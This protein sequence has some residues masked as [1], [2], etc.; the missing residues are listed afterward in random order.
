MQS[1]PCLTG[2][3]HLILDEIHERDVLSDFILT[4]LKRVIAVRK[5]L[6]LILMS[7]TLNAESFSK[8]YN[9]CPHINIPGF[10]YP[11]EEYY[12]EDVIEM[13]QFT[14]NDE[15]R[16]GAERKWRNKKT[17]IGGDIDKYVDSLERERKYSKHTCNMLRLSE[18]EEFNVDLIYFLLL[19]I[20]KK[21]IIGIVKQNI[22]ISSFLG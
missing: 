6:K 14:Y 9:D 3:S 16:R 2:V 10:T 22:S 1:D 21:V 18:S 20:C 11:V 13:T 4:I 12:L 8:Y 7:A 19:E 17:Y 5:D 15:R